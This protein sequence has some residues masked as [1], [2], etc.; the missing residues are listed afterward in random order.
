MIKSITTLISQQAEVFKNK[1]IDS[2]NKQLV[3]ICQQV[4]MQTIGESQRSSKGRTQRSCQNLAQEQTMAASISLYKQ[5]SLVLKENNVILPTA[6]AQAQGI[7]AITENLNIYK[8]RWLGQSFYTAEDI[9][10]LG[11]CEL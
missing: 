9:S 3:D 8:K 10:T 11:S 4:Q 6:Q 7:S 1:D 2:M 5:A